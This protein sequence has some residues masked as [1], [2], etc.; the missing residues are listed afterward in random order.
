MRVSGVGG[1]SDDVLAGSVLD[2]LVL[3]SGSDS[4]RLCL[5]Y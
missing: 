2:F 3:S 1:D 4:Y 5:L